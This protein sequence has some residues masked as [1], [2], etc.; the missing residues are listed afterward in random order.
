MVVTEN[1]E[2]YLLIEQGKK[3]KINKKDIY[4]IDR[5]GNLIHF[6]LNHFDVNLKE[7]LDNDQGILCGK[8]ILERLFTPEMIKIYTEA[9]GE[10]LSFLIFDLKVIP[11][12]IEIV[13]G[14]SSKEDRIVKPFIFDF[15]ECDFYEN[16]NENTIYRLAKS[17][18]NKN[19]RSY[20]P[21]SKNSY[22]QYF[23][24]GFS[25]KDINRSKVLEIYNSFFN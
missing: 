25:N 6:Y 17:M 21:N 4:S 10:L 13:L 1:S 3:K 15:N 23:L 8:K 16:I 19:G 20:F 2:V 9:I 18:Y 11:N 7:K 5:P 12:D 22:Y 14:T 24:K